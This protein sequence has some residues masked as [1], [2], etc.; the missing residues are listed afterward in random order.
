MRRILTLAA[1]AAIYGK[2][3]T[4]TAE[5]CAGRYWRSTSSRRSNSRHNLCRRTEHGDI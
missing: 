3:A 1:L 4:S 2:E 5:W